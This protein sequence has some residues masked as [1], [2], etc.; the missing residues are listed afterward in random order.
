[1]FVSEPPPPPEMEI[2]LIGSHY[3]IIRYIP[4]LPSQGV[5]DAIIFEIYASE[6]MDTAFD[7]VEVNL[8]D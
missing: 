1:M 7:S 8:I 2:E 6:N 4:L 3:T 5:F